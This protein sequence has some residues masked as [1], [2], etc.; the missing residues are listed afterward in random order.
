MSSSMLRLWWFSNTNF[1]A[2]FT[3]AS[4]VAGGEFINSMT[5][6]CCQLRS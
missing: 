4:I 2:G 3:N 1:A 6:A 5:T